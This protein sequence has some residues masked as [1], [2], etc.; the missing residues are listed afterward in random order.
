[1]AF[2]QF[3][4]DRSVLQA[5]GIFNKY[6]YE[7]DDTI[8][9]VL[10]S[11]YFASSR[12]AATDNDE[13]NGMGWSGGIIE[14]SCSDGY[15]VGKISEDGNDLAN[16]LPSVT[17]SNPTITTLTEGQIP[18]SDVSQKLIYSG[19]TV[20]PI[21]EEWTF[22]KTINVPAGSINIGAAVTAS[23]GGEDLLVVGNVSGKKGFA[24]TA[25]FDETGSMTP[26]YVN[27]GPQFN[28]VLNPTD[29]DSTTDNPLEF[30]IV[31]GVT[32]PDIRQTN[33]VT[34]RTSAPMPNV[35]SRITDAASGVVIRYIPDKATWDGQAGTSGLDF[36]AGDNVVDFI[37]TDP[38]SAGVFNV[39]TVPF[40]LEAGQQ[41]D[42]EIKGDAMTL[43]GIQA[44]PDFFPYLTQLIQEGPLVRLGLEQKTTIIKQLGQSQTGSIYSTSPQTIVNDMIDFQY[45]RA[46]ITISFGSQNSR[47]NTATI[48]GLFI[49]GQLIDTESIVE[50]NDSD[51]ISWQ[52]KT[53]DHTFQSGTNNIKV[54]FGR[55][56]G[57]G[58]AVAAVHD[59]RI[60]IKELTE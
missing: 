9:E 58:N 56:S 49:D 47:T 29:T 4:L 38:D 57:A 27:L 46:E 43:L 28:N 44:G 22:D 39:G 33:Q 45:E 59:L 41:I 2:T 30:S 5:R 23:E 11:G 35:A 3:K 55:S 50:P 51:D 40:R 37:S 18:K 17:G 15:L 12:F 54:L 31:G 21:T 52:S 48:L 25:D 16:A 26:D 14:C 10:T 53:L 42:I 6:V 20:D 32:P 7:T 34:F 19:A 13:T 24:L 8:A 36:I 1:M 60:H